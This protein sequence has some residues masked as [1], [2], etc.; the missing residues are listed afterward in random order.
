V[1]VYFAIVSVITVY[2]RFFEIKVGS[3]A[4]KLQNGTSA[5]LSNGSAAVTNGHSNGFLHRIPVKENGKIVL[6]DADDVIWVESYGNYLF[7]HTADRKHIYRETMAAMEGKLDPSRF[8]RIRRSAMVRIDHIRELHP[9][10]NSEFEIV[11]T[12]GTVLSST[13]R[14]RKNL[15]SVLQA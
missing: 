5:G 10:D 1:L 6:V 11:L 9:T 7:L 14:Y 13:R 8:L 2:D 3:E 12:N 4:K 15:E